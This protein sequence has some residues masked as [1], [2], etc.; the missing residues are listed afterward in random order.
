MISKF[1]RLLSAQC[2]P[3][4][5]VGTCVLFPCTRT[6]MHFSVSDPTVMRKD[7]TWWK[8]ENTSYKGFECDMDTVQLDFSVF[9]GNCVAFKTDG[10]IVHVC[11]FVN[12]QSPVGHLRLCLW[13]IIIRPDTKLLWVTTK[14]KHVCFLAPQSPPWWRLAWLCLVDSVKEEWWRVCMIWCLTQDRGSLSPL[15]ALTDHI[16]ISESYS[17]R[18]RSYDPAKEGLQGIQWQEV[19]SGGIRG[20]WTWRV[21]AVLF[22]FFNL[23]NLVSFG[24]N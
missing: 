9:Q 21:L 13:L 1:S 18:R 8:M 2:L 14:Q 7:G 17:V 6:E 16:T 20:D 12:S 15:C 24:Q 5:D 11:I 23:Q 3:G 10:F 4:S 19:G 22:D